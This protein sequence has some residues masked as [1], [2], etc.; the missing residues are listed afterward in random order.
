[1]K[2]LLQML[3]LNEALDEVPMESS[4]HWYGHVLRRALW[5]DVDLSSEE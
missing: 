4:M 3:C 2:N 5:F 1:M